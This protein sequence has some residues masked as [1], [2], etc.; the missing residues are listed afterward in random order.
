LRVFHYHF[1]MA[2]PIQGRAA[3]DLRFIRQTME[4]ST[5][6]TAVPG[7]GGVAM[8]VIGAAAAIAAALQPTAERWLAAWLLAA[9]VALLVGLFAM[10][11]KALRAGLPL[12]GAL[13]RRFALSLSAPLA[14]GAALTFGLAQSGNWALM[15][16][17]WL[18]LYGA[19]VITGGMVSVPVVPVVGVC[20][21]A[22]G[23][24]AMLTPPEWGNVWLGLGFGLLHLAFG[25]Y[26]ARKHGG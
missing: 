15:P 16:S 8:G 17:V 3:E 11:R 14:A 4:R 26:I 21:M 22:F 9:A 19:G 25:L 24:L 2:V 12:T 10:R 5:T 7:F 1:Q 20:F 18:L 6:F 23:V 13:A